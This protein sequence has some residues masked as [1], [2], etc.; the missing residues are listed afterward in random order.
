MDN[1]WPSQ[2]IAVHPNL[3]QFHAQAILSTL[4][5]RSADKWETFFAC[6]LH[7]HKTFETIIFVQNRSFKVKISKFF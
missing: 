4:G 3:T 1:G 5:A 6:F 2:R 7:Y